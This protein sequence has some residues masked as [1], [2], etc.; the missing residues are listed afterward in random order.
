MKKII[1]ATTII[2]LTIYADSSALS[3]KL[4]RKSPLFSG[5]T[6]LSNSRKDNDPK[7]GRYPNTSAS[8][9]IEQND[10]VE[11]LASSR[12]HTVSFNSET[13]KFQTYDNTFSTERVVFLNPETAGRTI[14]DILRNNFEE[15]KY[16]GLNIYEY[17][18][19]T[20]SPD[21]VG[22][23][24]NWKDAVKIGNLYYGL[25]NDSNNAEGGSRLEVYDP[26]TSSKTTLH[27]IDFAT[28][29][30]F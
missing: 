27:N 18:A 9:L 15:Y 3:R 14:S 2:L 20:Q 22:N 17:N 16:N 10:F 6:S 13:N 24:L 5:S 30:D 26:A 7:K 23:N 19:A 12:S 28:E 1:L 8:H 11:I 29:G 4:T 25:Y 21:Q